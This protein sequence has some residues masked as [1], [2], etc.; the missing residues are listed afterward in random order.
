MILFLSKKRFTAME[1]E[2]QRLCDEVASLKEQL[3]SATEQ[4]RSL[5]TALDHL[6]G[7]VNSFDE[8]QHTAN[9]VLSDQVAQL[10][11]ETS[12]RMTALHQKLST[13]LDEQNLAL[14]ARLDELSEH[15]DAVTDRV[16]A[17]GR[18]RAEQVVKKID[19]LE[20]GHRTAHTSIS[21]QIAKTGT[22]TA[23]LIK[24]QCQKLSASA[25]T[26][27]EQHIGSILDEIEQGAAK[28]E[29]LHRQT[30]TT[31]SQ[32]F[33]TAG[34]QLDAVSEHWDALTD[35]VS[36]A[37]RES[38]EQLG[39][40][41]DALMQ[42]Y[43][44]AHAAVSD[45]IAQIGNDTLDRIDAQH[46]NLSTSLEEGVSGLSNRL[47]ELSEQA[48]SAQHSIETRIDH[49]STLT[50]ADL[51]M[52]TGSIL[53]ELGSGA[54][55]NENLHRQTQTTLEQEF[56]ALGHQ[57]DATSAHYDTL[58]DQVNAA[59]REWAEQLDKKIDTLEQEYHTAQ[60]AAS[61][62][63]AQIGADSSERSNA[64]YQKLSAMLEDGVSALATQLNELSEQTSTSQ[65]S[66]QE[67]LDR[68]DTASEDALRQ[69]SKSL[70]DEIRNGHQQAEV[71]REQMQVA[72]TGEITS[73]SAQ[74][75]KV[76]ERH[77]TIE[78]S[79]KK[80]GHELTEHLLQLDESAR[81]LL[82]HT[83]IDEIG[84]V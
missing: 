16:S 81:L 26:E 39:N 50:A 30:Q 78:D 84:N 7:Q 18:E 36:A 35:R 34:I 74:L 42:G 8:Q 22:D 45:Q 61:E 1:Q 58:T 71:V 72:L 62:Q 51:E 12:D 66:L 60:I 6:G 2:F 9:T 21:N 52:R 20:Q 82:L 43:H 41:I 10:G 31:I 27:L 64:Q 75:N 59:G 70:L 33:A 80:L 83:V 13:A 55:K 53:V 24:T 29:M 57:L 68:S 63:I 56:S 54:A 37:E 38:A 19:A 79:I 4:N 73:L 17:V 28:N 14:I 76:E 46:L 77:E 44:T 47:N 3:T 11:S 48:Q 67:H 49:A 40:K 32:E 15:W 25:T 65:D 69:H 23:D 5:Q